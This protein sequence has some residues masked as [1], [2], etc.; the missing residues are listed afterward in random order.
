MSRERWTPPGYYVA[1]ETTK[2]GHC[3]AEFID[4]TGRLLYCPVLPR[5]VGR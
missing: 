2:C 5:E 3:G 1:T 4:H